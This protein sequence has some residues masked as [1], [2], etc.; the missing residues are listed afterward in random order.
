MDYNLFYTSGFLYAAPHP[1]PPMPCLGLVGERKDLV[2]GLG[3][4]VRGRDDTPKGS[5]LVGVGEA[6]GKKCGLL[7]TVWKLVKRPEA[8][9]ISH[10]FSLK[11]SVYKGLFLN[12]A[13]TPKTLQGWEGPGQSLH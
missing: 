6:I 1:L 11:Q 12:S 3:L 13:P 9:L 8:L 10:L 4:G 7:S 2:L 5:T